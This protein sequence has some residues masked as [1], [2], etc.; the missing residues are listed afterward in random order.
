MIH[1]TNK[2][3]FLIRSIEKRW[4]PSDPSVIMVLK[5]GV[6]V[7]KCLPFASL[8]RRSPLGSLPAW[9][10]SFSAAATAAEK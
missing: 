5:K 6:C 10:R 9:Y 2:K 7:E 4:G 1:T 8:R 3:K